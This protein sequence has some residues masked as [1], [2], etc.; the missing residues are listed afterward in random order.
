MDLNLHSLGLIG[1]IYEAAIE[2]P[3]WKDVA[4]GLSQGLDGAAVCID[5]KLPDVPGGTRRFAA[6]LDLDLATSCSDAFLDEVRRTP[7][8]QHVFAR[9]FAFASP[10]TSHP[11]DTS[12]FH[13]RWRSD[14]G[15]AAEWPIGHLFAIENGRPI[16]SLAAFRKAGSGPFSD[17]DL[18]FANRL[19]PHLAR[20]FEMYRAHASVTRQRLALAE[21]MD[22]LP[23]GLILLNEAGHVVL[24]SR[25]AN[26]I[27]ARNDGIAIANDTLH[28][29]NKRADDVLQRCI[30]EALAPPPSAQAGAGGVVAAPRTS[31]DGAYPVSISRLLPGRSLRDAVVSIIVSDPDVGAEPAVELLRSLYHLTPAEAELVGQLA[32][33]NSLEE[34]ARSRAV[35]INTARSHLKQIFLKTG[36]HRQGELVKLVLG[37]FVPRV[38]E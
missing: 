4:A 15:F 21:V 19:V 16:A 9:S 26:R 34:A 35:S 10:A 30:S 1:Q 20:A 6:G 22:R 25:S 8:S 17:G 24:T 7:K 12:A 13:E 2:P 36:T 18:A 32:R 11:I 3:R 27:L 29:A 23:A 33:G 37:Y 31:G 28:A 14:R 5:L 38:E